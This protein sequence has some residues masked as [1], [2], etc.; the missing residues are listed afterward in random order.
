[1]HAT[2][3]PPIPE[4]T[5]KAAQA[6][7]GS[8]NYYLVIGEQADALFDG[9]YQLDSSLSPQKP[10]HR[11]AI[12][13]LSTVFQHVESL[14]DHLAVDALRK[15]TDWKYAL[16]SSLN[17]IPMEASAL[18]EFRQMVYVDGTVKQN[19]QK[20]LENIARV[21]QIA[22][23]DCIR[24]DADQ[25]IDHV[26]IIS[27]LA[28]I[29][30]AIN[31]TLQALAIQ[32][33]DWLRTNSLPYWYERYSHAR[34]NMNL[35]TERQ[36]MDE[37]AQAIGSDGYYILDE[38]S[39]SGSADLANL[40]EVFMLRKIWSEQFERKMGKVIWRKDG[41]KFCSLFSRGRPSTTGNA[42]H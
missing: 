23:C 25:V 4:E 22:L 37:F 35:R 41:C 6:V 8:S 10:D 14:P 38:I 3:F 17:P 34:I 5:A 18:C 30:E 40:P 21:P 42:L 11:L 28:N 29:W 27:R 16:H 39:R 9:I 31:H 33:P 20:L 7:F 32:S 12:L 19:F 36:E 24:Q 26:C 15:R 1:M 2:F 13:Y